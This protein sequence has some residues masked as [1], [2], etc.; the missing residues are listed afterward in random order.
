MKMKLTPA[1]KALIRKDFQ[2]VWKTPMIRNTLLILPI[3]LTLI[4]PV[5][6]LVLICLVPASDL[7]GVE[8]MMKLLPASAASLNVQQAMFQILISLMEPMF[9]LMIPLMSS[10]VSAS[11]A[12]VGEKERGTIE[13]LLLT[14]MTVRQI[15]R[16]KVEMCVRLSAMVSGISLVFLLI[17][18]Q[19]GKLIL[20]IPFMID[21]SWVVMVLLLA[22]ALTVF[23]V[24]FMVLISGRSKSYMEAMQTSSYIV[25]PLVLLFIGQFTGLFILGPLVLALIGLAFVVADIILFS[26][27]A[28]SFTPEKLLSA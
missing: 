19:T 22:P 5:G 7:N 10:T 28:K 23:G 20:H 26:I 13:T 21:W 2:D 12:F 25:V 4:L 18:S 3:I 1:Q 17:V 24:I 27:A 9:F 11:G 6:Y 14:P 15:F 16:A 8:E